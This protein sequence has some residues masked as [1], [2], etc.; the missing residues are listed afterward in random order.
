MPAGSNVFHYMWKLFHEFGTEEEKKELEESGHGRGRKRKAAND[1]NTA[2]HV[3]QGNGQSF[4]VQQRHNIIQKAL[5]SKLIAEYGEDCVIPMEEN[6]VD[7]KLIQLD[8][9]A[10]YEVKS[11]GFAA[12]CIREALGQLLHY[13]FLDKDKRTKKL[14]VVGQ[15]KPSANE[16][17]YIEF[18]RRNLALEFEYL[19]VE[20]N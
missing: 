9:I 11:A 3:R 13:T 18:V 5:K 16:M 20:I 4:V 12:R 7:L 19:D 6:F 8:Y 1:R 2:P 14:I 15:N 17:A 10:F